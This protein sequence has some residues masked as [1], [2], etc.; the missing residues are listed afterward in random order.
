MII[1][2]EEKDNSINSLYKSSSIVSSIYENDYKKLTIYFTNG[3]SYTYLD[4]S[5]TDYTRFEMAESQGAVLN[6]H[7]KKYSY[8]KNLNVTNIPEL[9]N[10]IQLIE[11]NEKMSK[12]NA[13]NKEL[14]S[15]MEQ[16]IKYYANRK[17]ITMDSLIKLNQI[18]Q[19]LIPQVI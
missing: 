6:T 9:L 10:E 4:V 5:K 11:L 14:I 18:I 8:V 2:R 16:I 15:S 17:V 3:G 13:T 19:P 12:M 7:I 1:K